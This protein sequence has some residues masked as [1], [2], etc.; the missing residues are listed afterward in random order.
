MFYKL[1][2][3]NTEILTFNNEFMTIQKDV[4]GMIKIKKERDI[5]VPLKL[6]L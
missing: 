5:Y 6:S 4:L 1:F 3:V 2:S